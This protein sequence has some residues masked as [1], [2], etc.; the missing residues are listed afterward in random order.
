MCELLSQHGISHTGVMH[1]Q[2]PF[3]IA[4]KDQSGTFMLSCFEGE[5]LVLADGEWI[6]VK[7]GEVCLLPPFVA[8]AFK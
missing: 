5:G 4:R 8:N 2:F 7:A 1:A 6:T 3:E